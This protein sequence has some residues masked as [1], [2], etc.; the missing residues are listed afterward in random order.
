M[1][2]R[3]T[4]FGRSAFRIIAAALTV[5]LLMLT[6]TFANALAGD[7]LTPLVDTGGPGGSEVVEPAL[8][9]TMPVMARSEGKGGVKPPLPVTQAR[10][11]LGLGSATAHGVIDSS[12]YRCFTYR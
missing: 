12:C 2:T 6:L 10:G 3:L 8:S 5:L 1:T 11:P 9:P 4:I 7:T